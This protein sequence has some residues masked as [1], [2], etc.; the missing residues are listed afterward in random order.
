MI[1]I[2]PFFD[3]NSEFK[4]NDLV[5]HCLGYTKKDIVIDYVDNEGQ[6]KILERILSEKKAGKCDCAQRNPKGR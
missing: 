5:C 4:Y 1:H 6:S 2:L 3:E